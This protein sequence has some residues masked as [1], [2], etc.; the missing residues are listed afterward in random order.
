MNTAYLA[1]E[2]I[3]ALGFHRV[4][5]VLGRGKAYDESY[6]QV[7]GDIGKARAMD[8]AFS[9]H[10]PLLVFD[11][12]KE[13]YLSAFYLDE[14]PG[15][16]ALSFRLL[17]ENLKALKAVGADYFV[18][19][20]QGVYRYRQDPAVF[21]KRLD[22][23]LDRIEDLGRTYGVKLV[24]EYFG[25]NFMFCEPADWVKKITPYEHLGILVDTG[26]LYYASLLHGFDMME[27]LETLGRVATGF[28]LWTTK[29]DKAYSESSYYREY[30]HIV[31]HTD[32]TRAAGFAFDTEEILRTIALFHKPM[33]IEA[34]QIY[35]G[36]D[37]FMAGIKSV[38]DFLE[39]EG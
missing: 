2:K 28:H 1:I 6:R 26:H 11:W 33:V 17:E 15:K 25:S 35:G 18:L 9:I 7:M 19:H 22:E 8:L 3:K 31:V 20:F 39:K 5:F 37:Y 23:A 36:K 24:L 4:E 13:D 16:R 30:H 38:I 27:A 32:Q 34:S 14:D 29:A 12:F 10:L 21:E